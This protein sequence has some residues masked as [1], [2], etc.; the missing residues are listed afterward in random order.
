[1]KRY[2]IVS[3][4]IFWKVMSLDNQFSKNT[5]SIDFQK[6]LH[7]NS[8]YNGF[9][10]IP[11]FTS[12]FFNFGGNKRIVRFYYRLLRF[13]INITKLKNIQTFLKN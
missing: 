10:D 7:L 3:C 11:D 5:D 2:I 8:R 4:R 1:M 6:Y 13:D 12:Y 9:S